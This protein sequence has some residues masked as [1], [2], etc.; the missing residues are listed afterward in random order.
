MVATPCGI[1]ADPSP[2]PVPVKCRKVFCKEV[3]LAVKPSVNYNYTYGNL[4]DCAPIRQL[5][6]K[7]E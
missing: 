2:Y 4:L 5:G 7:K 6:A 1:I 3:S